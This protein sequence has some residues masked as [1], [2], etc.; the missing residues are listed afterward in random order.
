MI[1]ILEFESLGLGKEEIDHW[2]LQGVRVLFS[3]PRAV[4]WLTHEKQKQAKI[5]K[6]LHPMLSIAVG[7]TCTTMTE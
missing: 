1:D 5:M 4:I 3:T 2:D 7:V 6:V